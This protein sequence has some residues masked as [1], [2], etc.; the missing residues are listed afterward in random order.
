[1]S[2]TADLT[3]NI[4][5]TVAKRYLLLAPLE[6][7]GAWLC[8]DRS[9]GLRATL[10]L[11]PLAGMTTAA[12]R[13][14]RYEA[15]VRQRVQSAD[16]TPVIEFGDDGAVFYVVMGRPEG[17]DLRTVLQRDRLT[18]IESLTIGRNIL[19]ALE[20][21]HFHRV[22]HRDLRASNI[23]LGRDAHGTITRA[24]LCDTY[25]E[26]F[27]PRRESILERD[28]EASVYASP[29]LAGAIEADVGEAA[30]LYS[31]GILL[32]HCIAGAPPFFGNSVSKILFEHMTMAVPDLREL[33]HRV[34][35]V[36][37]E[38]I[39][40]L[41]QKEPRNRYQLAEAVRADIEAAIDAIKS[42]VDEPDV[43]IGSLDQRQTV[44]EPSFV[45]RQ[46]EIAQV[47]RLFAATLKGQ[48]ALCRI[49][50]ESGSGKTRLLVEIT[51]RA[52]QQGLWVLRG[53]GT[54]DVAQKPF[55][56]LEG[57]VTDFIAACEVDPELAERVQTGLGADLGAVCAALPELVSVFKA[58]RWNENAPEAFG[59][60]RTIQAL[61][62][63][64]RVLGSRKNPVLIV[65][66]DCQWADLLT[67]RLLH[68][69]ASGNH[70][71]VNGSFATVIT[72]FRQE[73][74]D[75]DHPLRRMPAVTHIRMSPFAD[76]EIKQIVESMAGAVPPAVTEAVIRTSGGSPFMAS[77]VLRGLVET[78][79]LKS[80]PSGWQVDAE[81]LKDVQSSEFAGSLLSRRIALLP[82]TTQRL[83]AIGAILGKEFPFD[84]ASALATLD[85]REAAH[86]IYEARQ[87]HLVWSTPDGNL[88]AFVHD[89]VR[90]TLQSQLS[91]SEKHHYHFLAAEHL[92]NGESGRHTEIAFHY[93][94][95]GQ[96]A[97]ALPYALQAA[98]QA[99]AQ[100]ALEIA[101][102]QFRIA[103]RGGASADGATKFRIANGLGNVL[104]LQGQYDAAATVFAQAELS[105]ITPLAKAEIRSRIA[106]LAFKRG[107]MDF[108]TREFEAALRI[109]GW[110]IPRQAWAYLPLLLWETVVQIAH[111]YL[112]KWFVHRIKR[113]PTEAE[114][115]SMRLFSLLTH[116]CW[117]SRGK[118]QCLWAHL[119]GLN[120]AER[121]PPTLELAHAYSEHAPVI[122]LVPMRKRAERYSLKSLALRKERG[123]LWG[124]GQ[125]LNFYSCV[126][127][128]SSRYTDCI[129]RARESIRLLERM[130]DYWQVHIARY[131]LAASLYRIGEFSLA[132]EEARKNHESGIFLGDEQASGIILDVWARA[133]FG[134]LPDGILENELKRARNDAQGANQVLC[135]QG[136]TL[137]AEGNLKEAQAVLE[138]AYF[139]SAKAGISNAYTLPSLAWLTTAIRMRA[140]SEPRFSPKLR[141]KLIRQALRIAGR[142]RA[143][144][145][146][147]AND[148]PHIYRECGQLLAMSGRSAQARRYLRKSI[149]VAES[150]QARY[151]LAQTLLVYGEIG[152][153][154]GWNDARK[155]SSQAADIL[156]DFNTRQ[157]V[158]SQTSPH[159]TGVTIS[160]IDRFDTLLQAGRE[161][162][163]GLSVQTI[164]KATYSSAVQLLRGES[165]LLLE[166]DRESELAL[167]RVVLGDADAEYDLQVV[168]SAVEHGRAT[169]F[170]RKGQTHAV[171]GFVC[172][173][174]GSGICAPIQVR[175]RTAACLYLT[176]NHVNGLFGS[177]DEHLAD[178]ICT[179]AGAAL[180]N[181]EG[182]EELQF[183]NETLEQRVEE[184]TTAAE[185]RAQELA[186]SNLELERVASELRSA[187]EE[188]RDAK[189]VA[190]A[191]NQAKSRFLAIM[192]HEIRTPMNGILGMTE[193]ALQTSLSAQQKNYLKVVKQSGDTLLRLLNDILD[194][195]KIEAGRMDLEEIAFSIQDVVH[196]AA[197]L[198][199]VIASQ[200]GIELICRIS[201]DV[202]ELVVGDP[203]RIRQ[204]VINL[205]GNAIKFTETGE[206][207][208]EVLRGIEAVGQGLHI[209]VHDTGPG[210]P[211][212]KQQ[213]IFESFRQSDSSTTRRYG[214]TGL[215]LSIS[216]QL[217]SLMEG[218]IWVE[219]DEGW[220]STFHCLLPL[221]ESAIDGQE[222]TRAFIDLAGVHVLF[223]S[224]NG[225]SRQVYSEVLNSAGATVTPVVDPNSLSL[226]C[227]LR[228]FGQS[229]HDTLIVVDIAANL[230]QPQELVRQIAESMKG[231]IPI[232]VLSPTHA[233]NQIDENSSASIRWLC[234]PCQGRDLLH[235][236]RIA[237]KRATN[238]APGCQQVS[239]VP[240]LQSLHIL[241]ADDSDVNQEVAQGL[242]EMEGHTVHAVGNGRDAVAAFLA[243]KFD[244]ILMDVEMPEMDGLEATRRIRA[245]EK[246]R[247]Q[248]AVPIVAMTAHAVEGFREQCRA[249]GMDDYIT[250][251]IEPS[252]LFASL[253]R[254][255]QL[256]CTQDGSKASDRPVLLIDAVGTSESQ[257]NVAV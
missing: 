175:G 19:A 143:G 33:G 213:S 13:R 83:L 237:V 145:R 240:Q 106:E 45:A 206:V 136:R 73:E 15:S 100:Y 173:D 103:D 69:W 196:D 157:E 123:D 222:T 130:G 231:E 88:F 28:I 1:M 161:I 16:L 109:L 71:E 125:S 211:R 208:V 250:K 242:L 127:Y 224:T 81:Q 186:I 78:G 137:I 25:V 199:A 61:A 128:Y 194:L 121:F 147:C 190:E 228:P 181:S 27:L 185:M 34:P 38:I 122:C 203:T 52:R 150:H 163:S 2:Q 257:S 82:D 113:S 67:W 79:A 60:A 87:R 149:A 118:I 39:Y 7:N 176:N 223:F 99:R 132:V 220:G 14:L 36:V 151:E 63:F 200:K 229:Q 68:R 226:E 167:P 115:L 218:K 59:E 108:A 86:A 9:S 105:A 165:C 20:S 49:E 255:S 249:A 159:D 35:R 85:P 148:L 8:E 40:R 233:M 195:T 138:Q 144:S 42:G 134:K 193:L 212:D 215:G 232:V 221:E 205:I 198:M 135:A 62:A 66:D 84:M 230:Q 133:D 64:L 112:P 116:G 120:L 24:T 189:E 241:L 155:L 166:F 5:A 238:V 80:T 141:R 90:A 57:V 12:A 75:D 154:L 225:T 152:R 201:T 254:A 178:F 6:A 156:T 54:S 179:I 251:P 23:V 192:S 72:A 44:V 51:Q 10:W 119:R 248:R 41:L 47:E 168:R 11:A 183:L 117:Y 30:D 162:A 55:R 219:S 111:T 37:N 214:G 98:E 245:T 174:D 102:R 207:F 209:A 197:R 239:E 96:P 234:K 244:A 91:Q 129:S 188:L 170:S 46:T 43:V 77:A 22:Y 110:R 58:H 216:A 76:A 131:Q 101:E 114:T 50:G 171:G 107:D 169:S 177:T 104:M 93:D 180:E 160:L 164:Y 18:L 21:L 29:E 56:L 172:V 31:V 26:S 124:Q 187:E 97:R 146:I 246:D 74:V 235:E 65:L 70:L 3:P 252:E 140:E 94:A 217:V 182:F 202:P 139:I 95:C 153:D 184:R 126:L 243:H 256:E 236:A 92:V 253:R 4:G 17:E 142:A 227:R 48:G 210:I 158:Q 191:A 204:I 53:F 89:K 247:D 32:Y